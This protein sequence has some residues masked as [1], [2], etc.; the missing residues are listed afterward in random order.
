MG[1][2]FSKRMGNLTQGSSQAKAT[3]TCVVCDDCGRVFPIS[4]EITS[5]HD[6][7]KRC[8]RYNY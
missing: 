7:K 2:A 5:G 6:K 1:I 3:G 4:Q 8:E